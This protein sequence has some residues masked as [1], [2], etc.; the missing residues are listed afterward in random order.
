MYVWNSSIIIHLTLNG[1]TS[2]DYFNGNTSYKYSVKKG[3]STEYGYIDG[4]GGL[5]IIHWV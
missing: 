2:E 1:Y 3:D 4:M 5:Q